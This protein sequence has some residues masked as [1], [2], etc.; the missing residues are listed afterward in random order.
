MQSSS[1]FTGSSLLQDETVVLKDYVIGQRLGEGSYGSVYVATYVPSG[2][3]FAIKIVQNNYMK[4]HLL[5]IV[6]EATVMQSL[7]H[8]HVTTLYKFLQSTAAFYFVLELA[9]GGELF[10]LII[11]KHYFRETDAR[12]YFQQLMSAI[13]YCHSNGV[14]HR[15]LKAE[16]LLLTKSNKLLV[17]DFGLSSKSRPFN[18]GDDDGDGDAEMR[19]PIGTLHYTS[20]E[21]MSRAQSPASRDPF[22]QDLW[23]AGVI[24]FFMLT[25]RLPFDGRDDEET[26]HLIQGCHV[27]FDDEERAR[28]SGTA[29]SLVTRMLALEPTERPTTV[30]IIEDEW[31]GVNLE[32]AVFPHREMPPRSVTFL[33]FS[34]QH[35]VTPEEEAVLSAA[36]RKVDIDGYGKITRDQIRDMLTALHGEKVSAADVSELIQLFTGKTK[37]TYITYEQFRDAWVRKDLAHCPFKRQGDFQLLKIIDTRMDEVEREVVRQLRTAFDSVDDH[38]TGV[39]NVDQWKRLFAR[40]KI[41]VTDEEIHSLMR[42]FDERDLE[43]AGEITFDRF[44]M[45]MVK[46]EML[47]RHPMGPKLAKATNLAA[48]LQSR[49]LSECVRHGFFVFGHEN[50]VVKKLLRFRE[51]LVL[52][53]N[54]DVASDTENVY[55]F[56]Y[57]GSSALM[58]GKTA[59]GATP[60]LAPYGGSLPVNFSAHTS[61][62]FALGVSLNCGLGTPSVSTSLNNNNHRSNNHNNPNAG[63]GDSVL[64][65]SSALAALDISTQAAVSQKHRALAFGGT[66]SVNQVNGVCDVDV[67]L[68]QSSSGYTLVRFRRIYGSTRD[69]H[70]AVSFISSVLEEE[71]Q[72]AMEDTQPRGESELV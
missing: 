3:K 29:R 45:G 21:M 36:F 7:E 16:N 71:R 23:S 31:F 70:E 28:I 19:E 26:V 41:S 12:R 44:L 32:A 6:Q 25:G 67:I 66:G 56:R 64:R 2:K 42:F 69:F 48:L 72:R 8:P 54:D 57:A 39:I 55:S 5:Q 9:E 13:D 58:A 63:N 11:S 61:G 27:E 4:R 15:D 22:L 17:C 51:R 68:S 38:H 52:L 37:S 50:V 60:M 35:R 53:Y 34:T 30:Q 40:C 18:C 49:K 14:A 43:S 62:D 65:S 59:E 1:N 46:R 20:P 24:L 47:V 10:D 33:D